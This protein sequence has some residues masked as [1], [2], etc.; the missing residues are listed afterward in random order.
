[1]KKLLGRKREYCI[2][3]RKKLKKGQK[4]TCGWSCRGKYSHSFIK[5]VWNK[6]LTKED[7]RIAKSCFKKGHKTNVGKKRKSFTEE[8]RQKMSNV[9]K[10]KHLGTE[11]VNGKR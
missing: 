1:M 11:S 2:I 7:P 10:G 4:K 9:K 8:T 5:Q 3:C 6:G